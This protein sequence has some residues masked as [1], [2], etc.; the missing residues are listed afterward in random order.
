MIENDNSGY[1]LDGSV[2]FNTGSAANE[3]KFGGGFREAEA[4]TILQFPRNRFSY[5]CVVRGCDLVGGPYGAQTGVVSIFRDG[6]RPALLEY[7]S[8]WVQDTISFGN[9]TANVGLRYDLQEGENSAATAPSGDD[10]RSD[11]HSRTLL[12]GRE[13][14]LRVGD[15]LS[16]PRPDLCAGAGA[17][18]AAARQLRPLRRAARHR[19]DHAV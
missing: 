19:H 6:N 1:R 11:G 10:R 17:Q 4:A 15:H 18:D 14:A 7:T 12:S 3:L 5:S 9:L 8:A 13:G 2:F 16:P